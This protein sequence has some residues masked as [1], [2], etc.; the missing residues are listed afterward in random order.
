[1]RCDCKVRYNRC[2]C[3]PIDAWIILGGYLPTRR[4]VRLSFRAAHVIC[5]M[6][7]ERL[8]KKSAGSE[9][10]QVHGKEINPS[11]ER[12]NWPKGESHEIACFC[13][14]KMQRYRELQGRYWVPNFETVEIAHLSAECRFYFYWRKLRVRFLQLL[15]RAFIFSL[16]QVTSN[17]I[18]LS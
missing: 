14:L 4:P 3:G 7:S 5:D 10:R 12:W 2:N 18:A 13:I 8:Q 17:L 9:L 6:C 16:V 15:S 1:M 11:A